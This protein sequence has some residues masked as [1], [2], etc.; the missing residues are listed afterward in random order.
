MSMSGIL[1]NC[2]FC[3]SFKASKHSVLL[4][5]FRLVHEHEPNFRIRCSMQACSKSYTTVKSYARHMKLK[6]NQLVGTLRFSTPTD[7]QNQVDESSAFAVESHSVTDV[8]VSGIDSEQSIGDCETSPS[9]NNES[10]Q[11]PNDEELIRRNAY[12]FLC[13]KEKHKLTDSVVNMLVSESKS[14]VEQQHE[15]TV[16]QVK[17][18]LLK[19]G[20]STLTAELFDKACQSCSSMS[21]CF[22]RVSTPTLR[23]NFYESYLGM[24]KPMKCK[25]GTDSRKREQSFEY[26]SIESTLRCLLKDP[27]VCSEVL[28]G[29]VSNDKYLRDFCDGS[30]FND[31]EGFNRSLKNIQIQLYYDEFLPANPLGSHVIQSKLS[32]FYYS[33][34]NLRPHQRSKL[35]SIQLLLLCKHK[36]LKQYGFQVILKPFL[37]EMQKLGTLG[38]TVQIDGKLHTIQAFVSYMSSDNLAC[39]GISGYFE[40]FS[41][42]KICRHCNATTANIKESFSESCY[43]ERTAAAYAHQCS[44][45]LANPEMAS[46]Y[47]LKGDSVLNS[48]PLFHVTRG[49]PFDVAHDILEGVLCYVLEFFIQKATES[50]TR[51]FS[52]DEL[53]YAIETF[54]YSDSDKVNKP[55]VLPLSGRVR[56]TAAQAWCLIRLFPLLIGTKIPNDC[57]NWAC[58]LKLLDVMEL[59]FSHVHTASSISC[60]RLFVTE[61][62]Q[63]YS[64][65]G[66]AMKPKFHYMVHYASMIERY[67]PL[68]HCWTLRF[69]GKH[70]YFKE[71]ANRTKNKMNTCL[72]LTRRHQSYQCMNVNSTTGLFGESSVC[73]SGNEVRVA[74]LSGDEQKAMGK[75]NVGER[76]HKTNTCEHNGTQYNA[77]ACVVYN[78][79]NG[80]LQFARIQHV[81]F[82]LGHPYLWLLESE[83]CSYSTHHHG[84]ILRNGSAYRLVSVSV[85]ADYYPLSAYE[86]HT[87]HFIVVLRHRVEG[88]MVF[89]L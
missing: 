17:E 31:H 84:Y 60:V 16:M 52:I 48:L 86:L 64:D 73:S 22:D 63:M 76:V 42:K 83:L 32:G 44:L 4:K 85:L 25:L 61:F 49:T 37:L 46:L 47:G 50:S 74:M 11:I 13:A 14:L 66:G 55:S 30:I 36:L 77:G 2:R 29:H 3:R 71:L 40:S 53:N 65:I 80:L 1:L 19:S 88:E 7:E 54:P 20:D 81:F 72:S 10:S 43:Q 21:G 79:S 6:H 28:S 75:L 8:V 9:E 12:F 82:I 23:S 62:L 58:V 18:A 45:V 51:Y 69:E 57:E 15:R 41:S 87:G 5:H 24:V 39:H 27:V 33:I 59:V 35:S 67:G 68:I 34:G 26:V 89:E 38:F 56:Q 78:V 70:N